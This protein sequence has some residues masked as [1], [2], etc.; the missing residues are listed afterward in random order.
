MVQL[1]SLLTTQKVSL[2]SMKTVLDKSLAI[3]GRNSLLPQNTSRGA[4]CSSSQAPYHS[5]R[6]IGSKLVHFAAPPLQNG[7]SASILKRTFRRN[8]RVFALAW[9]S[10]IPANKDARGAKRNPVQIGAQRS[11]SDLKLVSGLEV[12]PARQG[13]P[14]QEQVKVAQEDPVAPLVRGLGPGGAVGRDDD[15]GRLPQGVPLR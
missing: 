15:I 12:D 13:F 11:G 8:L 7:S 5:L 9:I 10:A 3:L 2:L 6:P 14:L 4:D 1:G